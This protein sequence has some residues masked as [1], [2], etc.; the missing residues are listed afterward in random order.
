MRGSVR[1]TAR[2]ISYDLRPAKQAERGILIDLLKIAGDCGL[3][4][5]DYRYVGMGANRFYDF[6]LVHKYLGLR[7]MVSLE[8]D[9][10]MYQR[11]VFNVP[12]RF[13]DVRHTSVVS[14]LAE[15][16]SERP[17]ILWLDYDGGITPDVVADIM[18][19]GPRCK[20]GDFCFVTVAGLPR[21]SL[22][23]MS[24]VDR[25]AH[26]QDA[27]GDV[28]GPLELAD[29][30]RSR[31]QQAVH[32][33]LMTAFK[34]AF[35]TRSEGRF[36]PLLQVEYADSMRMVTVGGAFLRPGTVA[37]IAR[38]L[39][40]SLPFLRVDTAS[41]YQIRSFALTER[42]RAMFDRAT[43]APMKRCPERRLLKK[44]GFDDSDID[45]YNELIRYLPR[46]VETAV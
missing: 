12:Y 22:E 36:V 2:F 9:D 11:A 20:V 42:E 13:I 18:S 23:A 31:F 14:F 39:K 6:L 27:Y 46:Y 37:D 16:P 15:G 8:H 35:A 44:L 10:G 7:D 26:L 3:P 41:L 5:R 1:S 24:D 40:Q 4:I 30:E 28:A 19:V 45:A 21:R 33:L 34:S 25:L 32:K 29:V 43:T 17:E 38:Q